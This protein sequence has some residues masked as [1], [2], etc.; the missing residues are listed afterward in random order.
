MLRT[1]LSKET[2]VT[3][4]AADRDLDIYVQVYEPGVT[5]AA[6]EPVPASISCSLHWGAYGSTW[7]DLPM[8]WNA[9]KGN[10][11][12]YRATLSQS[13][14]N[15]LAPGTY[16]FTTFCRREGENPL[17]RQDAGG[18]GL[19]TVLPAAADGVPSGGRLKE[20]M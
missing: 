3:Q 8:T 15:T 14:L 13:L 16:G 18:D 7:N 9:Q 19:L 5:E 17:W 6:G 11:D 1:K 12:E 2:E 10:N 4:A 20:I